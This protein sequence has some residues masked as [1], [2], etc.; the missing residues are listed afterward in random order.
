MVD[1]VQGLQQLDIEDLLLMQR[2]R[3]I[4]MAERNERVLQQCPLYGE[5]LREL[6][7][8]FHRP[9]EDTE[10]R[11]KRSWVYTK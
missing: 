10:G 3:A 4:Q 5:D 7:T 9:T 2:S 11:C 8:V 6:V 1:T